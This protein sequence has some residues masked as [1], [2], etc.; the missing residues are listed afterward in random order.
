M[1]CRRAV[2]GILIN[3]H[4]YNEATVN[5][6]LLFFSVIPILTRRGVMTVAFSANALYPKRRKPVDL[7]A[8]NGDL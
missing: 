3:A 2:P 1:V 4:A 5:G 7:R 8:A 6:G